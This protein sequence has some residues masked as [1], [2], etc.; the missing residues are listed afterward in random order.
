MRRNG[1]THCMREDGGKVKSVVM[2][3]QIIIISKACQTD[4]KP[5]TFL[6]N[7]T[8]HNQKISFNSQNEHMDYFFI[9]IKNKV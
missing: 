9:R 6:K 7:N 1:K 4:R 3:I 5:V 8:Q 2:H